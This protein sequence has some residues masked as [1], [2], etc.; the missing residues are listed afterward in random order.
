MPRS[1]LKRPKNC[2]NS[3]QPVKAPSK[4]RRNPQNGRL[5]GPRSGSVDA[6]NLTQIHCPQL[7][8]SVHTGLLD[9]Y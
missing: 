1:T 6:G 9:C 3:E 8:N 2:A 5:G 7:A 4:Q